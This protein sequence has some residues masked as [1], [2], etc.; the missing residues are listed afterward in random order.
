MSEN[1]LR[2]AVERAITR[3]L[4]S[5]MLAA[6]VTPTL[7]DNEEPLESDDLEALLA[8]AFDRDQVDVRW[9]NGDWARLIYGNGSDLISDFSVGAEKRK[10]FKATLEFSEAISKGDVEIVERKRTR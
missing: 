8:Y 6:G 7:D 10:W 4:L 5:G 2:I 3:K 9:N 1:N